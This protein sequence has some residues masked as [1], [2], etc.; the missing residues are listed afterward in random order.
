[1]EDVAFQETINSN[2][3]STIISPHYK[4]YLYHSIFAATFARISTKVSNQKNIKCV[5]MK[6]KL[7]FDPLAHILFLGMKYNSIS[8]IFNT[9]G[10]W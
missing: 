7:A 6:S 1:M 8:P 9:F 5:E 4:L 10:L 3:F 2:R